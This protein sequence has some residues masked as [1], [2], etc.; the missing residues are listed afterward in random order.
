MPPTQPSPL[1]PPTRPIE[2]AIAVVFDPPHQQLLICKRKPD[3]VLAG[4]WEFPGGKCDAGETPAA[5]A[6]P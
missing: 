1:T 2:V 6:H 3:T 4:Y 5:C